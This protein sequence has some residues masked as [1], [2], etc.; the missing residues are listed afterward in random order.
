MAKFYKYKGNV[1]LSNISTKRV[2]LRDLQDLAKDKIWAS[3][4]E[5]LN[6]PSEGL[7]SIDEYYKK[8]S[9]GL[10]FLSK[11]H[12]VKTSKDS[13][14][15]LKIAENNLLQLK[16]NIAGI[17]S[18]SKTYDNELMWSHYSSNHKGYCIEY[19]F[20][21]LKELNLSRVDMEH[22]LNHF[23]DFVK[24]NYSKKTPEKSLGNEHQSFINF[25]S[26]KS[27]SW[28]YEEEYRLILAYFGK[29][30]INPNIMK[31]ITFGI[32]SS[33]KIKNIFICKLQ[34]KDI[35]FYEMERIGNTYNLQRRELSTQKINFS[36]SQ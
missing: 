25:L 32:N 1:D 8:L 19:E 22:Y 31:S 7:Y 23:D 5:D 10:G 34:H 11:L 18:L 33:Q 15:N 17:F 30:Y 26:Q 6:D 9:I 2:F 16:K 27:D 21:N 14:N 28:K 36:P 35:L 29:Y 20:D 24:I 4:L 3:K 13:V 12:F